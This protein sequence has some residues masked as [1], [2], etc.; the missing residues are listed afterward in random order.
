M[1]GLWLEGRIMKWLREKIIH[2]LGGVTR[3]ER[4]GSAIYDAAMLAEA[5]SAGRH[6]RLR[7]SLDA[8]GVIVWGMVAKAR[9][10]IHEHVPW[11]TV[12]L[13][14][15]W[16]EPVVRRVDKAMDA[17]WRASLKKDGVDDAAR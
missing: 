11:E 7:I 9:Q 4:V 2:A 15:G 10:E 8:K 1:P 3:T 16:L 6:K 13:R 14:P 5:L 17:V 12:F